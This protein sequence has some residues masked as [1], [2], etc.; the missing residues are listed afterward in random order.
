MTYKNLFFQKI[1]PK[2]SS[3]DL[4]IAQTP[5]MVIKNNLQGKEF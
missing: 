1:N 4:N 5:R 2:N 3:S